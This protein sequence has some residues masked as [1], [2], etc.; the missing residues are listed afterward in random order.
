MARKAKKT[1]SG[2]ILSMFQ[3][4]ENE[5]RITLT[6]PHNGKPKHISSIDHTSKHHGNDKSRT[7]DNLFD[8][9]KEVL[10][11]NEKWR[12]IEEI[13]HGQKRKISEKGRICIEGKYGFIYVTT[14]IKNG[15]KYI[16]K[17]TNFDDNYLG[18]GILLKEAIRKFGAE[19]FE[20]EIIAYGYTVEQLNELEK[21][22]IN[23]FN[24]VK[25]PLFYN[26][27]PGGDRYY[28]QKDIK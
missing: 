12:N 1:L 27:A 13:S 15:M 20:R 5:I 4:T 7:H 10:I 25:N 21:S 8:F 11:S 22:Y 14:N 28:P 9:F 19:N 16:G 17:H 23:V 26:I 3:W 24:A 18:S 6:N 2:L